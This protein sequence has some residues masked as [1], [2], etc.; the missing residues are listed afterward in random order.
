MKLED[1]N[2]LKIIKDLYPNIEDKETNLT[3][4]V[5][6]IISNIKTLNPNSLKITE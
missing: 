1:I 6:Q 2:I 3:D 5:N 4:L